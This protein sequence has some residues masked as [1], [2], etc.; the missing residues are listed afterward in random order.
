VTTDDVPRLLDQATL[1][2]ELVAQGLQF[3]EGPV[4][5]PDGSIVVC[6]IKGER[7]THVRRGHDGSW[8]PTE[9]YAHVPGGP[10]G[11]ALGPDE[12]IY[13]CNNGGSFTWLQRG[14][15][16]FPGPLP[17]TWTGGR[18][19]RVDP[20]SRVVTELYRTSTAADGSTVEL[21]GPND[22]VMDGFGGFWFTDHGVRTPRQSDRTGIHYARVDG[23]SCREVIF[24]VAEPNG[25][26]LSPEGDVVY[27][28]E[29]HTGRIYSR[30]VT[31]P[32]EV[33][34]AGPYGGLL[35]GLPGMQLLDS[36]AVDNVGN[37]CVGTLIQS[38][39]TIV[40]P[41]GDV[42]KFKLPDEWSDPM[43][44]N[45]AFG[46]DDL[47]TAYITLSGTGRLIA[48]KWPT[49]GLVLA[50]SRFSTGRVTP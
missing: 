40:T 30:P 18:I 16:T 35:A 48:V 23:S 28:A 21:R 14:A 47:R 37:I 19:E 49:P 45:I 2:I 7:L 20:I 42:S 39:I 15:M 34:L 44:T 22:L 36:L 3:P 4:V 24:P 38:G 31:A 13:V 6:E 46:G 10:N 17:D 9:Q 50:H 5:M 11:A 26:G 29:T 41:M 27:W 12:A 1:E 33:G 32:G 8:L 43:V 25:I